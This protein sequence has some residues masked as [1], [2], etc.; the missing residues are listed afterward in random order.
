MKQVQT[1]HVL[2]QLLYDKKDYS[3]RF[4]NGNGKDFTLMI[5]SSYPHLNGH[6][7]YYLYLMQ[8]SAVTYNGNMK[9]FDYHSGAYRRALIKEVLLEISYM[10]P[11]EFYPVADQ[12]NRERDVEWW[13]GCN[14]EGEYKW[15]VGST[16]AY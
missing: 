13:T 10:V 15:N 12:N 5:T 11:P 4:T 2:D 3:Q 1:H 7:L 9:L 16:S 6:T 14:K 8:D